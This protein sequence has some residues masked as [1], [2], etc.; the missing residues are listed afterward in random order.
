VTETR[1][2]EYTPEVVRRFFEN[3]HEFMTHVQTGDPS[4][5]EVWV[6]INDAFTD[7]ELLTQERLFLSNYY[8]EYMTIDEMANLHGYTRRGIESVIRRTLVKIT[9]KLSDQYYGIKDVR[10]RAK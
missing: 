3:Y 8:I 2:R 7:A 4:H 9:N 1:V 6:D 5:V 10:L